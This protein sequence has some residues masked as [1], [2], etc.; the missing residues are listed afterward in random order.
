MADFPNQLVIFTRYPQPGRTKTRL[1]PALGAEGAAQVQR[2]MAEHTLRQV[3]VLQ[4]RHPVQVTLAFTG[5]DRPTMASWLGPEWAYA[6][7]GEGDLGDRLIAAMQ[8]AFA[9]GATRLVII[10]I[11]C[12]DLDAGILHTAFAQLAQ[13]DL[14]LGPAT[15]GGY[16]LIGLR[17]PWPQLFQSIP[18]STEMVYQETLAIAH[19]LGLTVQSLP[20]LSDVDYPHDLAHWHRVQHQTL[21]V[22]VPV[23]NEAAPLPS[24]LDALQATPEVEVVVVDGGSRDGTGAIAQSR[25]IRL[26]TTEPGRAGQMNA[27]AKAATGGILMFLHADTHLPAGFA[28]AVRATLAQPGVVA[29]AFELK[30]AGEGWGL[31]LVEWGVRWRSRLGQL[32]YGDQALFIT[33]RVFEQ[34]GGFPPLP[35]MEDFV[36]VWHLRRQGRV[37][38]APLAV[39]TSGRRWKK[40]GVW[41]TTLL[42]Q[43]IVLAY[44][45]GVSPD[46]LA[47]WYRRK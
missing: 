47:Y 20:R 42:N 3:R 1:I 43:I 7:Q 40:L 9:T 39:L 24:L 25:A 23:L 4:Q 46:R 26:V 27:G 14:V 30:I 34:L 8:S 6:C 41:K 36:L 2:Q 12:P 45:L 29:G 17:S 16:Y 33:R 11:D 32:P 31:R 21:S 44:F 15:D 22:I 5:S 35:I 18:W 19:R 37:A 10:G 13:A 38:I 28:E